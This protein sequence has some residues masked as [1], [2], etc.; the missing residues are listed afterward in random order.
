[1]ANGTIR[2]IST[3]VRNLE[4]LDKQIKDGARKARL[5]AGGEVEREY[6][7]NIETMDIVDTGLYKESTG[8]QEVG[9]V[10]EAGSGVKEGSE[11]EYAH[12]LEFGT[13]KMAARPALQKAVETVK[14]QY[15]N[16]IIEDVKHEIKAD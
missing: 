5:R 2:G 9:D 1:M 12:Y 15:P 8:S 4:R 11:I 3:V 14:P 7:Q 13:S 6:V 10:V 16:M